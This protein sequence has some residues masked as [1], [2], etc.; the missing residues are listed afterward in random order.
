MP[1][2]F[3]TNF[4]FEANTYTILSEEKLIIKRHK[5]SSKKFQISPQVHVLGISEKV[6]KKFPEKFFEK[7]HIKRPENF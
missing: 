5:N 1:S 7:S 2:Y 3:W 4:V 6:S